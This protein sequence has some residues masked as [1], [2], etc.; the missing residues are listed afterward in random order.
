MPAK[1]LS[2]TKFRISSVMRNQ[3][4]AKLVANIKAY[5]LEGKWNKTAFAQ[6]LAAGHKRANLNDFQRF[7]TIAL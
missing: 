5:D 3:H 1:R 6:K 7:K 2:L 4:Q